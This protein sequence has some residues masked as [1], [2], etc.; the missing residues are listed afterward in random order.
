[1]AAG[2]T[3]RPWSMDQLLLHPVPAKLTAPLLQQFQIQTLRHQNL[4][5]IE[6]GLTG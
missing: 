5:E 6:R 3:D 1:M 4:T 2:L